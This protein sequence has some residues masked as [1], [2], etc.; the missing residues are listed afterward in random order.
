MEF[1]IRL[2][3]VKIIIIFFNLKKIFRHMC[4][5]KNFWET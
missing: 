4:Y 3:Y 1:I 5:N 2:T